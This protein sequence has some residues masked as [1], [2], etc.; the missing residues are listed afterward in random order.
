MRVFSKFG[1][2]ENGYEYVKRPVKKET[3]GTLKLVALPTISIVEEYET[4]SFLGN[5]GAGST[6][7]TQS[8]FPL[9]KVKMTL[10]TFKE[11]NTVKSRAENIIDSM[12]KESANEM[13][14][15]LENE[16]KQ[17]QSSSTD[18]TRSRS[19]SFSF[20]IKALAVS[21]NAS[22][23]RNTKSSRESSM[24][25]LS[26][27]M[28]KHVDKSNSS[29][30]IKINT[31]TEEKQTEREEVGIEREFTNPNVSR[32]LNF[33]FRELLQ[34][35]VSIT[36]LKDIKVCF[37]NR[38]PEYDKII[39]IE[40][41]DDFLSTYLVPTQVNTIKEQIFAEYSA[42]RSI[43]QKITPTNQSENYL[44]PFLERIDIATQR[45][46]TNQNTNHYFTKKRDLIDT[47]EDFSVEG[48]ILNVDRFTLRTP[49][50]IVDALLG[51]GEALD[52][53]GQKLQ[54]ETVRKVRAENAKLEKEL[55]KMDA[56]ITKIANEV[57]KSNA[58]AAKLQAEAEKIALANR[59]LQRLEEQGDVKM[60]ADYYARMFNPNYRP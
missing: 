14:T 22:S 9:E 59:I 41:L 5:Y 7:S 27:S 11:I 60:A 38:H 44:L 23:S 3:N 35:Y 53:Y 10:K 40:E 57:S 6:K 43:G 47:Y 19:I 26:K 54:D 34:E 16:S 29:R 28:Q 56:E 17:S 13:E 8:L 20:P 49:A 46:T 52:C 4:K 32:V 45:P 37:S 39:P 30:E 2:F 31:S 21:G 18:S 12:S 1:G 24:R 48:V 36:Y 42:V 51:Q 15:L 55:S 50:V 58:E 33:V 25:N